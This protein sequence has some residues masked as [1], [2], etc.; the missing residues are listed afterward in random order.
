MLYKS[1]PAVQINNICLHCSEENKI[2]VE[3]SSFEQWKQGAF[4]QDAFFT[5]SPPERE[6]IKTGT[7][8]EC[9][10]EIFSSEGDDE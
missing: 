8:P 7:H 10:A 9:W 3:Q 4:I 5:L 6:L 1:L 2:L